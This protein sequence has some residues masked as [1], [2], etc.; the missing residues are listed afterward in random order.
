M[1]KRFLSILLALCMMPVLLLTALAA[2]WPE[3]ERWR[4]STE[5]DDIGEAFYEGFDE[6]SV[7][8]GIQLMSLENG[9]V[10]LKPTNEV[11][12]IDRVDLPDYALKLYEVLEEAADGDGYN[13]YFI[14]DAYF[15]LE[16]EKTPDNE[17]GDF[18]R[19]IV[20]PTYGGI[21]YFTGILVTVTKANADQ[22]TQD[23]IANCIR[24][25][26]SA[27]WRD[28]SEVFWTDGVYRVSFNR[29]GTRY[30]C[31]GL[32]ADYIAPE[33]GTSSYYEIRR[34]DF[35]PGGRWDI[36]RG[37]ARQD[38]DIKKILSTIPAGADRL[39]QIYYINDWLAEN[40][41]YNTI[42]SS[43]A[44]NPWFVPKSIT[45]LEGREGAEGPDCGGYA[46]AF[47]ALC[48]AL[49]IPC[50]NVHGTENLGGSHRWNYVQMEDGK[51]YAVDPNYNDNGRDR[52]RYLLVG[53]QT[54]VNGMKFI[55]N[56]IETN[57][58]Y[59]GGVKGFVNGPVLNSEA[60][61]RSV[62]LAYTGMPERLA[63]GDP[64]VM[65]P[66]LIFSSN[67]A[68]VYSS[69][70]LP[71]GLSIDPYTGK[72]TGTVTDETEALTVTVT[73]ASLS[74]PDDRAECTLKFPEV[75]NYTIDYDCNSGKYTV[76]SASSISEDVYVTAALYSGGGKLREVKMELITIE[77]KSG[78][79][80]L[81][82]NTIPAASDFV[83]IFLLDKAGYH[84][85][86]T[87][88]DLAP[89]I[90]KSL[91]SGAFCEG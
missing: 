60:Y 35:R 86:R 16:G 2:D 39:T 31:L 36:R 3:K 48:D 13:D 49:D 26:V 30:Y 19:G 7:G 5:F 77:G 76:S 29:N 50:V 27:F 11:R 17:P 83:K 62:R 32:C 9:T 54:V 33:G 47:K 89:L 23:Y 59:Y 57:P 66:A 21:I 53:G 73:A 1:R 52:T 72:I 78:A 24:T 88:K 45:A 55:E 37:I 84:P 68:Y 58:A 43:G 61:P 40:N 74:D 10:D 81:R 38:A 71:A 56:H 15:D 20:S 70:T 25:V 6:I 41:G 67:A 79:G 28:H 12:W 85:L 46:S 44:G 63:P 14:D 22:N 4:D 65:V 90:Q 34:E 82:F 64:V 80:T 51:W 42:V 87:A 75:T 18:I 8:S 91:A 69:T